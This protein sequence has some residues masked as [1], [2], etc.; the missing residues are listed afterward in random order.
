MVIG[1]VCVVL[2]TVAV[3]EKALYIQESRTA[4]KYTVIKLIEDWSKSRTEMRF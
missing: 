2:K 4:L 1:F 3:V